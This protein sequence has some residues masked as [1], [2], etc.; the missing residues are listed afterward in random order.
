MVKNINVPCASKDEATDAI[1]KT[2]G[3]NLIYSSEIMGSANHSMA[4]GVFMVRMR[5]EQFHTGFIFRA[6]DNN[7]AAAHVGWKNYYKV[8]SLDECCEGKKSG[9]QWLNFMNEKNRLVI[10]GKL[11]SMA[12]RNPIKAPYGII[13]SGNSRINDA[14]EFV[15][16]PNVPGDSLTCAVFVLCVLESVSLNIINRSSWVITER[17]KEWQ[18]NILKPLQSALHPEF[19]NAQHRA[20]GSYPRFSPHQVVGSCC[21]FNYVRKAVDYDTA[22]LAAQKI[23]A[24][25]QRLG[26]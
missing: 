11:A 10:L 16:D 14:G 20:I 13:S 19:F 5:G 24:E 6:Q 25:I 26:L 12:S 2:D 18:R 21:V 8:E 23:E 3:V 1:S 4:I 9:A 7:L 15:P 17:D 22:E